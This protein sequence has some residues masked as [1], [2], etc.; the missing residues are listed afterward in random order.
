[1]IFLRDDCT[2]DY[3][4]W[5]MRDTARPFMWLCWQVHLRGLS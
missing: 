4:V 2:P 5:A 1:V 3:L